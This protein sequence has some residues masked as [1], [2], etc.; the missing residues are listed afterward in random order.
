M[1]HEKKK[2]LMK[3]GSVTGL[4]I[5]SARAFADALFLTKCQ[6]SHLSVTQGEGWNADGMLNQEQVGLSHQLSHICVQ[7]LTPRSFTSQTDTQIGELVTF[8]KSIWS[9]STRECELICR[10]GAHLYFPQHSFFSPLASKCSFVLL[11]RL[12]QNWRTSEWET[13]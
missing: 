7:P 10:L 5:G 11:Q 3:W 12:I 9:D 1:L 13:C 4:L 6:S 8:S 2:V